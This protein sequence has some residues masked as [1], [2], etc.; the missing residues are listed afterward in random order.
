LH[1]AYKLL[2]SRHQIKHVL[3]C[4][5]EIKEVTVENKIVDKSTVII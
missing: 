2:K 5:Q 1:L 3:R 4:E